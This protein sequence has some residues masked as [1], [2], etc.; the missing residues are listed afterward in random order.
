MERA[1]WKCF[2][3]AVSLRFVIFKQKYTVGAW[4]GG[5]LEDFW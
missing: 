3:L 5:K 2:C 1:D 4:K